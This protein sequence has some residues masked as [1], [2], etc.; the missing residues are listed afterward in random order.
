MHYLKVASKIYIIFKNINLKI[1]YFIKKGGNSA[2]SFLK[3]DTPKINMR[4]N[5]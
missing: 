1:Q 3:K 5:D 2:I 4:R